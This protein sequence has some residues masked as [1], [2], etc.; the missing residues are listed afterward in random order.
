MSKVSISIDDIVILTQMMGTTIHKKLLTPEEFRRV[1]EPWERLTDS[2][3]QLQRKTSLDKLY[4]PE[5][6]S[7]VEPVPVP[8]SDD[9]P[10]PDLTV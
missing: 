2:I 6:V 3:Q 7:D 10:V 5:D 1:K 9:E 4:P 8:V